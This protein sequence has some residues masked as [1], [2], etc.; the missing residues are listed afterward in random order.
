MIPSPGEFH[1]FSPFAFARARAE[2]APFAKFGTRT[3]SR[4]EFPHLALSYFGRAGGAAFNTDWGTGDFACTRA[5][6]DHGKREFF[7]SRAIAQRPKRRHV[8]GRVDFAGVVE[9]DVGGAVGGVEC[10]AGRRRRFVQRRFGGSASACGRGPPR[11][12]GRG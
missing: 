2:A 4:D 8:V 7:G 10:F 9:G 3:R 12:G 11:G 6:L 5:G 1:H